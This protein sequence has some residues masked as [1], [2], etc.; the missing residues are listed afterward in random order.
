MVRAICTISGPDTYFYLFVGLYFISR[1]GQNLESGSSYVSIVIRTRSPDI[2]RSGM[3]TE[4]E[5]V[6]NFGM[7]MVVMKTKVLLQLHPFKMVIIPHMVG[8]SNQTGINQK[9]RRKSTS[10]FLLSMRFE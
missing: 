6:R 2:M 9:S 4:A 7:D 8:I 10:S 5:S 1:L 3:P